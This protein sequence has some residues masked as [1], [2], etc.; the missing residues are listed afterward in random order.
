MPPKPAKPKPPPSGLKFAALVEAV[1]KVHEHSAAAA[2]RAVNVSLTLRNWLIGWHVCE[3][4]QKGADR[5]EY[6]DRLLDRLAE[7]LRQK[8]IA[9]MSAR[10]LR[11]Y[12]QFYLVYPEIWQSVIAKSAGR[13]LPESIWQSLIAKSGQSLLIRE[14]AT[15]KSKTSGRL[16]IDGRTLI[17]RLSF[18]H[19]AELIAIADPL[20]RTFYEIECIRG[21][22]SVRALRRQI[23]TLYFERSGLSTDKEKLAARVHA[24]AE[25]AKP[26]LVI[27]DPYVF[28]FLGLRSKEAVSESDLEDALLDKLQDF[29]LE[30]GHQFRAALTFYRERPDKSWSL[31]DCASF[32]IMNEKGIRE[33]LA[34]DH[35]FEQ[36]G[37][38]ALLRA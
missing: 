2:S 7:A 9:D 37:Y 15:P 17:G 27:R 3:Y 4:E 25:K 30:L 36:A 23:A 22:W 14:P 1:R 24:A 28:E 19:L 26:V 8:Q 38:V 21:N 13:D 16:G 33:A 35:H 31:V 11:L 12:R 20:K 32:L 10:S 34:H 18:T 5:A 29:L 6:G